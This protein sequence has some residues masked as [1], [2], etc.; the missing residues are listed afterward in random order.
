MV[1]QCCWEEIGGRWSVSFAFPVRRA[2]KGG[3]APKTRQVGIREIL[4]DFQ[5]GEGGSSL[6]IGA[7]V[8]C[9]NV[10]CLIR[11]AVVGR[12]FWVVRRPSQ[13]QTPP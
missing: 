13:T 8:G 10:A 1:G 11:R 6:L 2:G 9:Y 3:T 12:P 5:R 4:F 7:P